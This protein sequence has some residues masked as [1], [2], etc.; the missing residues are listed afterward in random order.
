MLLGEKDELI[1]AR[2]API[3]DIKRLF[4]LLDRRFPHSELSCRNAP[5]LGIA[6]QF[7]SQGRLVGFII[8]AILLLQIQ[9]IFLT[10]LYLEGLLMI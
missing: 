4:R 3:H 8:I 2:T 1:A 10:E 5:H 7:A 6:I 9:S